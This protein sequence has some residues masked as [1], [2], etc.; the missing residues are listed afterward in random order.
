[1]GKRNKSRKIEDTP[2]KKKKTDQSNSKTDLKLPIDPATSNIT[3]QNKSKD[4]KKIQEGNAEVLLEHAQLKNMEVNQ[5]QAT[6]TT[7]SNTT[8]N[9]NKKKNQE[10]NAEVLEEDAKLDEL[11]P[12]LEKVEKKRKL[13]RKVNHSLGSNSGKSKKIIFV[14][15]E[16]QLVPSNKGTTNTENKNKFL[17][18]EEAEVKDEDI[19][20]FCDELDEE[21]NKQY[22]NWVKLIEAKLH[23]NKKS[24]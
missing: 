20:K 16:P 12:Q 11:V 18:D 15:D 9:K 24:K 8:Q 19:D 13:K 3:K 2:I 14:D 6:A 7:T 1:M 10:L 5:N 22:E 17:N 21:D 4:K 23:E